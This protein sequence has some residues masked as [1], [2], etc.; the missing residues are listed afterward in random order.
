[1]VMRAEDLDEQF[2]RLAEDEAVTDIDE[3]NKVLER[4]VGL[5]TLLSAD[6]RVKRVAAFVADHFKENVDPLGYKAFLV[7]V[8]RETC[9]KYKRA[10]D[11]LLPPEWSEVVYSRNPND[12]VDRPDV[13]ALQLSDDREKDVRRQFKKADQQPKILIVTDKLLTGYDAPILYAMYL[14]KPMRDH[15][16]LQALARVNRPYIDDENV[17][18]RVGL[19]VDFVGVLK[20]LN[21]ALRFDSDAVAGALEDLETLMVDVLNK[22]RAAEVEYLQVDGKA[23]ADE[24]LESLVYGKFLSDDVR[25]KFFNDYRDIEALWEI[26][27]PSAELRDH[28]KTYRRLSVLYAAVRNAYSEGTSFLADL[29]HKT[30]RLIE[31]NAEQLKLGRFTKVATFDVETLKGLRNDDGPPEEKVYNLLR[32]LRKEIDENP[33]KAV[34]LQSIKDRADQVIQD[35]EQRK[36]TGL[37]ALDELEALANE[38]EEIREA[39][40]KS[41]LSETAFSV[42]W[43][44]SQDTAVEATGVDMAWAAN[45]VEVTM[46]KFPHWRQNPDE[47]RR[48]RTGLYKPLVN[49]PAGPR[50]QLIDK[51]MQVLEEAG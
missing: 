30:K 12:V 8:D 7:A 6:D 28:I 40:K 27:S 41:G 19:V 2:F 51:I 11:E 34:V 38:K 1:M 5:R 3:L 13:A 33:A 35:L 26:L 36:I 24:Q 45:E 16:L 29:E 4:A 47:K 18:K 15:V 42:Y 10:L 32:G 43:V 22:I 49:L 17:Q 48:L 9:A 31:E 37:A 44:L 46:S 21:K 20:E 25:K 50:S 23:T 14:D 39:A